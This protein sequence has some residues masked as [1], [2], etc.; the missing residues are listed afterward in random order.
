MQEYID[1]QAED[2]DKNDLIK[3]DFDEL[4]INIKEEAKFDFGLGSDSSKKNEIS[5]KVIKVDEVVNENSY[6]LKKGY[7]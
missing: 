4:K 2:N 1:N 6:F 5:N 3:Q 7:F